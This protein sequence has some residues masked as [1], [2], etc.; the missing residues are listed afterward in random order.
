MDFQAFRGAMIGMAAWLAAGIAAGVLTAAYHEAFGASASHAYCA[1]LRTSVVTV[2]ALGLAWA[3]TRWNITEFLRLTYPAMVLGAYRLVVEDL[4][5]ERT[6]ALFLSLLVYGTALMALPRLKRA[7][8]AAG[9][10]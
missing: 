10:T 4:R 9:R 3:G 6:T 8:L 7:R 5:Q 1:T 2:A